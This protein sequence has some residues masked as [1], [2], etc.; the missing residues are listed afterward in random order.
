MVYNETVE[1]HL[2]LMHLFNKI[3]LKVLVSL[4]GRLWEVVADESLEHIES[5]FCVISIWQF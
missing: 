1:L 4:G 5:K 2:K 3:F